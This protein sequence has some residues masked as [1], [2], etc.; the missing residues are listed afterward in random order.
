MFWLREDAEGPVEVRLRVQPPPE[1]LNGI[2]VAGELL[3]CGSGYK[4]R[5][6]VI[7]R[8]EPGTEAA[9]KLAKC[10]HAVEHHLTPDLQE[11]IIVLR[12]RRGRPAGLTPLR[13]ALSRLQ[14]SSS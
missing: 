8:T 9:R 10:P 12:D 2:E 4:A 14:T 6:A 13:T 11:E 3:Q 7:L 5:T 1:G